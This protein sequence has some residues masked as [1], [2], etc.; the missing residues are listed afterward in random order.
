MFLKG[1]RTNHT[2]GLFFHINGSD[3]HVYEASHQGRVDSVPLG[4]DKVCGTIQCLEGDIS[5]LWKQDSDRAMYGLGVKD[6]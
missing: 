6:R 4:L 5:A 2:C 1:V 3:P